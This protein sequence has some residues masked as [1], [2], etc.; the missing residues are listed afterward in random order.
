MINVANIKNNDEMRPAEAEQDDE[1]D[2]ILEDEGREEV[3]HVDGDATP[4][5]CDFCLG[6]CICDETRR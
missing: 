5:Y 1:I 3:K 6:K 4:A 2:V